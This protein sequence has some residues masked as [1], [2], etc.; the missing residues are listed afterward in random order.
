MLSAFA[1]K[2]CVENTTLSAVLKKHLAKSDP[3][4]TSQVL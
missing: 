2:N 4:R 3:E 1:F